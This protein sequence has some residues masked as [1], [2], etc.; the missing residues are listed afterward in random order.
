[1]KKAILVVLLAIVLT[2]C[3]TKEALRPNMYEVHMKDGTVTNICSDRIDGIIDE[4]I[5]FFLKGSLV[6][7]FSGDGIWFTSTPVESCE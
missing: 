3:M 6:G 1:M 7:M 4:G 5:R 2:S